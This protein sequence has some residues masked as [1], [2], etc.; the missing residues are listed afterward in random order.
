LQI[1]LC[2]KSENAQNNTTLLLHN[3][4]GLCGSAPESQHPLLP[5][6]HDQTPMRAELFNADQMEQ[7]GKTLAAAHVLGLGKRDY[8]QQDVAIDFVWS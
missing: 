5:T 1:L 4:S 6:Y 2:R 8:H 3:S 7:H